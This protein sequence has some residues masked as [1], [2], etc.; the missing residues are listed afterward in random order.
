M[1]QL[2]PSSSRGVPEAGRRPSTLEHPGL[3][4]ST[5]QDFASLG[6]RRSEADDARPEPWFSVVT[7]RSTDLDSDLGPS[8]APEDGDPGRGLTALPE[9]GDEILGFRLISELGRGTFGRVF[10]AQ[11][12]E[13]ADRPVALKVTTEVSGEPKVL[14]RLQHTNIVPIFSV[15]HAGPVQVVC[16]PYYGSA[17]LLDVYAGLQG[18]E[19]LPVSGRALT[20]TLYEQRKVGSRAAASTLDPGSWGAAGGPKALEAAEVQAPPALHDVATLYHLER[21]TYVQAVLW[22]AARLAGGLAHAHER[23][24]LHRDL[25]PANVLLTDE[26][27]PMLLDFNLAEDLRSRPA[28]G[29]GVGGTLSYMAPEHLDACRG[30]ARPVDARSDLYALGVILYELLTG[31]R[32]FPS[33]DGPSDELIDR[34]IR[35]RLGAPPWVRPWNQAVT[36]ATESIVR[37]CL[38]PDPDHR[39]QTALE[40][41]EDLDRQLNDRPLKHAPEPSLRERATKWARRHPLLCSSSTIAAV[42]LTLAGLAASLS[43]GVIAKHRGDTAQLQ[44]RVFR[45]AFEQGQLWLNTRSDSVDHL[46]E[47]IER[48]RR[49][50]DLYRVDDTGA[51]TDSPLVTY[52]PDDQKHALFEQVSELVLLEARAC[53]ALAEGGSKAELA[54][55][56]RRGVARLDAAERFDPHPPAAL[57]HDRARYLLALGEP[58]RAALDLETAAGV[59]NESARDFDLLGTAMLARGQLDAAEQALS[60]AIAKD[61]HRFW[62]WLT[63]GICHSDQGRPT[64][65]AYDFSVCSTLAPDAPWVHLNRGLA[66]ARAGRLPEARIAY[67]RALDLDPDMVEALVDRALTALELDDPWPACRDLERALALGRR[68]APIQTAHAAALARL[69]LRAAAERA[70]AEVLAAHPTDPSPRVARGFARLGSD[71]PGAADD[72]AQAL[73]LDSK[74]ARAHLGRAY[75]LRRADLRAALAAADRALALDPALDDALELRALTRARLGDPGAEADADRLLRAPTPRRLYNAACCLALLDRSGAVPGRADRAI[76]LLRRALDAG[77]DPSPLANDPDLDAL[78]GSPRFAELIA[79]AAGRS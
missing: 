11:Q 61:S 19:T 63:L 3:G 28:D 47:G 73:Q 60:R 24:I 40:L 75:L 25:K 78:R 13:L 50:L 1:S 32:P 45:E 7:A 37:R 55:A 34:M 67:D 29:G 79:P 74:N 43:W 76:D 59:V 22:V 17:T 21:L 49:A 23:G 8:V 42:A 58:V 54:A 12:G 56:Q 27:Q 31:R 4:R 53:V 57:Y 35:D 62:A 5:S 64:D 39:Y 9:V 38:E 14:A 44:R 68:T 26:G 65:A 71:E 10:L 20:S 15:H 41:Q 2:V 48:A 52:L 72:F 6:H 66:L 77:L 33:P 18:Q 36:P 70:F 51:W 46:T 30:G 16:M 69:N